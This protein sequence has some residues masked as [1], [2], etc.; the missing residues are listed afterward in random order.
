[1]NGRGV[2]STFIVHH[3]YFIAMAFAPLPFRALRRSGREMPPVLWE[4][5]EGKEPEPGVLRELS[6]IG[7]TWAYLPDE[8]ADGR[9]AAFVGELK[10]ILGIP[11]DSL[12]ARRGGVVLDRLSALGLSRCEGVM[13]RDVSAGE[14]K[15]GG[16]F[17]RLSQLRDKGT[18]DLFFAEAQDYATGEWLLHHTPAHAILLPFSLRDLTAKY[19]LLRDAVGFGTGVIARPGAQLAWDAPPIDLATDVAF[20]AAEEAVTSIL[21]PL[22]GDAG[23]LAQ[24]VEALQSPMP[25]ERRAR[26]WQEFQRRV[27][28]P[29]PPPRGVAPDFA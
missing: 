8:S 19:R 7:A 15:A 29:P 9:V 1:M 10:L 3:S 14:I 28:E 4:L 17:H 25:E 13:L 18:I 6:R 12:Q 27:P 21:L 5:G 2:P 26:W 24:I 22:P 20:L 16:P 11:A 23:E